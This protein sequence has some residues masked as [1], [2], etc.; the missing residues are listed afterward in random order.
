MDR[1]DQNNTWVTIVDRKDQ[2]AQ[3]DL[4]KSENSKNIDTSLS[5]ST[6]PQ[7]KFEASGFCKYANKC[8]FKHIGITTVK[9]KCTFFAMGNCKYGDKCFYQHGPSGPSGPARQDLLEDR[10][11]NITEDSEIQEL[12]SIIN[13][14]KMKD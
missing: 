11:S 5:K 13:S 14:I 4:A 10:V 7:C 8:K 6:P 12:N 1:K 3:K 2:K 9:P